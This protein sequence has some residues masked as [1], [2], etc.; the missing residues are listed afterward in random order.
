MKKKSSLHIFRRSVGDTIQYAIRNA[1][2][3]DDLVSSRKLVPLCGRDLLLLSVVR[4]EY[5]QI[6]SF[7]DHYRSI[8]VSRFAIVDDRSEDGTREFL[9]S[10]PDVDMFTSSKTYS[11][12]DRGNFWRHDLVRRYG[13][14]RWYVM[15]DADEYL[16]YDGMDRHSLHDLAKWIH[17][18]G[19]KHL[20]APMIDMYPKGDL[21]DFPFEPRRLPWQIADHFDASGYDYTASPQHVKIRGG[22]RNRIFGK[23]TLTK[24]PLVYWDRLTIINSIHGPLPYWRNHIEGYGV[25][26]H[27]KFFADFTRKAQIAVDEN[28]HWNDASK[29]KEYLSG[30]ID[31]PDFNVMSD[32]SKKYIGV[33]D[34]IDAGLTRTISWDR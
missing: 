10:Q 12:S 32:V 22:P 5:P 21:R 4:N 26:L 17:K 23:H 24:Y 20:L 9:L 27:F 31:K 3:K 19:M 29:Y 13:M 1:L 25:L 8:G 2:R 6:A 7:L 16:V 11:E 34:M 28:Q 14:N 33:Q 30:T 18:R 15:V